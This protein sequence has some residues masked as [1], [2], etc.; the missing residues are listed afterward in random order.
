MNYVI[1]LLNNERL[2]LIKLVGMYKRRKKDYSK[3]SKDLKDITLAIKRL[4]GE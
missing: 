3:I 1:E 4:S 2:R